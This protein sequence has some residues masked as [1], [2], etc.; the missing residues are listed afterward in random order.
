MSNL[1]DVAYRLDPVL[2]VREVL[3]V[4]PAKWQE[5][6]LRAPR[7]ASILALTAR[8]CGKTT[9]A[10][11]AMAHAA[12]FVPGSL[13]V[14]A[15]PAQRQSAEAVRRVRE[16]I[17][18]AGGKLVAD[19]VY[20]LELTNGSRVLALPGS[21]ESIR[22]LTVDAWIVA[23]EAARLPND[24]IAALRPMRAR[25]PHARFAMLSTAWSRTDPFWMAWDSDDPSWIRLKATADTDAVHYD[26][27]F[28]EKE[29]RAL[30][31]HE[32][33]RE[34]LGIPLGGQAS[35]F[36]WELSEQA[37]QVHVPLVQPG[38]AFGPPVQERAVSVPN[39]FQRLNPT[40]GM[41]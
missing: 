35:P 16:A 4:E 8:Q 12:L 29:R 10:A 15:C 24:L 19:N 28:L 23:D 13:S 41:P 25:R 32:F 39:P 20:G 3:G 6:F 34:Y 30:G 33:K 40:G 5:D 17:I 26:P 36:T 22:G 7:G 21:D 38:P 9:T 18:K 14:V 37:T 1:R 27:E 11:W 2:W 31:E